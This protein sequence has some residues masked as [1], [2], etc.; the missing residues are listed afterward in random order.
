M[1][2]VD[3]LAARPLPA[4]TAGAA[5]IGLADVQR[6][7]LSH[8]DNWPFIA[9]T[10]AIATGLTA[11]GAAWHD[12]AW[13]AFGLLVFIPQEYFTHVHLLHLRLP[14]SKR[15]YIGLYRLHYGHHDHPRRH[16][17]MYMPLW[18]TLPM[19]LAN[20][21]LLWALTPDTRAFWAAF[22]GALLGYL[23]FEWSH[24]LCHVPYVPKSR[25]WRHVR[26]QHL[27]HHFADERRGYAVAP[28]A[29]FMDK[30]LRTQARRSGPTRSPN[31]RFLGLH[32]DHPWVQD[33]R[34][35]FGAGSSGNASSSRLWLRAGRNPGERA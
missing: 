6:E 11:T 32:E 30:L 31:C 15:L 26:T 12:A 35:R 28:W 22:G 13:A 5:R 4:G 24:L 27:M 9:L 29:L 20:M 21:A 2:D 25:L 18:L 8:R 10:L 1:S 14:A 33:A 19:T 16:D 23:V 7:F 3:T 34:I 17:L